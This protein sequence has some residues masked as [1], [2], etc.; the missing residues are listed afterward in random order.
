MLGQ[1]GFG[2]V[3]KAFDD[4]LQ[5]LVAIKVL[6]PHLA[7]NDTA[8]KRFVRE[9][10][11]AARVRDAHVVKVFDVE[12]HPQPY[13]VMEYVHG[14]TLEA[15]LK[16][17][18]PLDVVDIVRIGAQVAQGLAAAH[19]EGEIHRD[20]KPAN[21]LLDGREGE[22]PEPATSGSTGASPSLA[23]VRARITDFGL[24]RALDDVHL[25]QSGVITGTPAYM[26]PEQ[27]R[28]ETLDQRSD[29]FSLG[30]VLCTL[31]TGTSPFKAGKA[32]AVLKR[33]CD[34][35]PP[36]I[37]DVNPA[38][39][40]WLTDII[41]K[42][43]A[44]A[45][46]Q[47]FQTA[48][49]IADLLQQHLLHLED[50]STAGVD[51]M[52]TVAYVPA[53][54][55]S[56]QSPGPRRRPWLVACAIAVVMLGS[57]ASF[58]LL[59]RT[60]YL[61]RNN[62]VPGEAEL[63]ELK[64]V[65]AE[66]NEA[67]GKLL[68]TNQADEAL[69]RLGQALAAIDRA[70]VSEGERNGLR[71][72]IYRQRA[73]VLRGLGR[74]AEAQD[75]ARKAR[76]LLEEQ[77]AAQPDNVELAGALAEFLW[78]EPGAPWT[79]LRPTEMHSAGGATLTLQ[80]DGSVL[81]SGTNSDNDVYT[82]TLHELPASVWALRLELLADPSLPSKGPGRHASGNFQLA[83]IDLC[84]RAAGAESPI[85]IT[86]GTASY[87]W[88]GERIE[89]AFDSDPETIWHVWSRT[90]KDHWALFQF[91]EPVRFGAGDQLIVRLEQAARVPGTNIGRFRM[92]VS[93]DAA[94][95]AAESLKLRLDGVGALGAAYL[96]HGDCARRWAL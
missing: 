13:L 87:S 52:E 75:D 84:R 61:N 50:P 41:G 59:S 51:G 62:A 64:Q 96:Y 56:A 6:G 44:K 14:E 71:L 67:A 77:Y 8:R 85:P 54:Q 88:T 76:P 24:A 74:E 89:H 11:A 16:R 4:K 46:D 2:I 60:G 5:R 48:S 20:I 12:E 21:I 10:R 27:A 58:F 39:P 70:R 3:L 93:S 40:A 78:A 80:P 26:S 66:H 43:L 82:V 9:A 42:L 7:S 1:G 69:A 47:R 63:A 68:Q 95:L 22:A 31:C 34:D 23:W 91:Q 53:V 15:R 30:S 32:L 90:G 72:G 37:R 38:I 94:A 28:G 65:V 18:G 33:V 25:T 83:E 79:V 81:A 86:R 19:R 73:Q 57:L 92:S 55:G 36:P 45:P 49:E 17:T 29:L 35:A